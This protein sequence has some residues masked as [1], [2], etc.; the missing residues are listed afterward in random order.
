VTVYSRTDDPRLEY[1]GPVSAPAPRVVVRRVSAFDYETHLAQPGLAAPPIVVASVANSRGAFLLTKAQSIEWLRKQLLDPCAHVVGCN[2]AFD[3]VCAAVEDESLLPSIFKA[4]D[5]DRIH[6]VAIREALID[7]ARGDLVER[8]SEGIGIRYGMTLL[9]QRYFAEDLRAEKKSP[10]AW[11]KRYAL[12]EGVPIEQWPWAARVYPMRDVALPLQIF[13]RQEGQPNLHDEGNQVRAAFALALMSTWGIRSNI[14]SVAALRTRV[15][16]EDAKNTIEF[17]RAGILRA[18]GTEDRKRLAALVADA[19]DGAPPMTAPTSKFPSGQVCSDRDTLCE[20]GDPL[21][22][23][24]GRA[25]KNDKYLT[26]YLEI[27]ES[28]AVQPWNP[29]F[30]VLVATTRVSS[31][32]QQFPQEGGVRECWS[33]RPGTVYCSVDYEGLE[34]RTMSQRALWAVGFSLMAQAMNAGLDPHLIAAA[35]FMGITYED[36]KRRYDAKDPIV[37]VFRDLGKIWNFG[38]GG[39]M[40]PFAMTFNARKGSKGEKTTAPDGTVYVGARFC[41][42]AGVATMCGQHKTR[43]KVQGKEK[44]VCT[45]C[46]EVAKKLDAG[47]LRAWPEQKALFDRAS[48]ITKSSRY[49]EV[50]I[51]VSRVKRGKCGYTQWL[52]TPFQGL[53]AHAAKRAMWL[54]CKETYLDR[55]SPLFGSRLVLNV[56]DELI[57]EMPEGRAPEAGDRMADIM[58]STLCGVVPDLAPS[59]RAEPALSRT[60]SKK[61]ATVRDA[62]GRLQV[63]EPKA[64]AA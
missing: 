24:Y 46:L 59:V 25:G 17:Q 14:D 52:N 50:E 19:Y 1:P 40:G 48:K 38:K 32:A 10:D 11:R 23:R 3:L 56:H 29:Q 39:G 53:G 28:G 7:I 61:A 64:A 62:T 12:L 58:R 2:L 4:L 22:E 31:D 57:A 55:S 16:A 15:E 8:G 43:G 33:A 49:T 20:S 26:T 13:E 5:E 60:M 44:R 47:W 42:L 34:L 30:N 63:W 36:A 54:I 18:D 37:K 51:P 9:A 6:D 21:L 35:S 41:I 27:L 45:K